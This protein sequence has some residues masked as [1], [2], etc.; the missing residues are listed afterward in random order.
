M[1]LCVSGAYILFI[2]ELFDAQLPEVWK[3]YNK[4]NSFKY[5]RTMYQTLSN[6]SLLIIS[7]FD[8]SK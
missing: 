4:I 6:L 8:S 3:R 7:Y 2:F 5:L 1:Q